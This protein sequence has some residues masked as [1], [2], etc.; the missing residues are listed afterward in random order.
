MVNKKK[1]KKQLPVPAS[2]KV[3]TPVYNQILVQPV[4]RGINDIG[5]WKSALR[6]ADMGLRSKLYDL[7]E[8]VLLDGFVLDAINKRIEAITDCDINFLA[9]KKEVPEIS[10]LMDTIEFENQLKEI[11]WTLFL[12]ISVDEY[13]FVNGFDFN[14]IPRKHIRPKEKMIVRQ[15]YDTTGISYENDSMIIQW[16]DDNDLGLLLKIAPYVIYKRGGFG[17]WAQFVEL[18]GMP[19][20][21]GKYNSMDEQS[22]RLLIQ[23]FEEAGAAPYL[24][25]PKESEVEQTTLSGSTNGAL[26]N[27]FRNACNEE[28]LITVLGQ[29]MTTQDGASLSQ[30]KVHMEVQEKKHRSDRRFVIRMLNKYLVP[31]LESRGYPVHGGKFSFVDK[32]DEITVNDL[33]TLST[34]IPIPRSYGYEKYGIPEPKDGEEVF[35]GTPGDTIAEPDDAVQAKPGKQDD[36][37]PDLVKNK[38]DRTLWERVKSFFVAAPH[39]GGAGTIRMSD[40]ASLD[41]RIIAAVWNGE[42][43]DFSPELFRYFSEDFLKAIQPSF[44]D[45]VKNADIGT[46]YKTSDDLYRTALEQNLFHF[47]AAK[48]LAEV[49]ELNRLRRESKSFDEFYNKAK[50]VTEVFNKTW[51]KTEW[52]TSALTAEGMSTYR[53]L[54]AKKEVY[55]YWEYLTVHDGRVREEHL[56]LHGVILPESDPRWNLIYPPN[57]W[58]CRCLV[59]GRMKH[60][61]KVNL[62]EMRQRVDDFLETKEWKINAA[63]GWGV[64]RCDAAQIFTAN[65]MYIRKFPQQASSYL[66][67][68]TAERWNLPKV[69][70]MKESA[71]GTI[72]ITVQ[73]EI[74]IWDK[75][76]DGNLIRLEDYNRKEI[77]IE[78]KQFMSHTS[79]KGRDNRIKY[80]DAM[81]ETLQH[82]DEV[83]L[84]DE[85]K[86]DWLDTYCLLKYYEDE[87]LAVNYRIEGEQLVLKTW[88]IMQTKAPGN[89]KVNLKKE[90]WDKRRRGLLIKKR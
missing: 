35:L 90:I 53:K 47:S 25:I 42:L 44:K 60:Q 9:N 14:S 16:G 5:S 23:A 73:D 71:N 78:R 20:R 70:E 3:V 26:Y 41:E 45:G 89:R 36:T 7:Y 68:M 32:K 64:N 69:Q 55:P 2:K 63:Q 38:D 66:E 79:G 11:M 56:K 67:K 12:G 58:L 31:L 21:I 43:T 54:R 82:P 61:V 85:I 6:A 29:T 88:Y 62:A 87:V 57:G 65:Q 40:T 17:D 19:Q 48:S 72:P 46:G 80:W 4:H 83:W 84:N 10:E 81:L 39:P 59:M 27:D 34:M 24:V 28:I 74:E 49:Q 52:D 22:R 33:K 50:E 15:Q 37:P 13:S 75:Y 76:A 30:S 77:V 8:D 1:N 51:Q 86:H 18:F